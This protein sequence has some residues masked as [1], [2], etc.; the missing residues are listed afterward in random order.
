MEMYCHVSENR[1][2]FAYHK[3]QLFFHAFPISVVCHV[4]AFCL[5]NLKIEMFYGDVLSRFSYKFNDNGYCLQIKYIYLNMIY[6]HCWKK[7]CYLF[8]K[9]LK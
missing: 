2:I 5:I 8:V 1:D 9:F 6:Q 7:Y 3:Y 4:L